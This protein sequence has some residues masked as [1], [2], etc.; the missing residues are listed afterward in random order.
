MHVVNVKDILFLG[1]KREI[2][3]EQHC[4]HRRSARAGYSVQNNT[5]RNQIVR[6]SRLEELC[7]D[8]CKW[9]LMN[10]KFAQKTCKFAEA[11]NS[12]RRECAK[13]K[14]IF[15]AVRSCEKVPCFS[16]MYFKCTFQRTAT[17]EKVSFKQT[18]VTQ[19]CICSQE[20]QSAIRNQDTLR[21]SHG[22][23][24]SFYFYLHFIRNCLK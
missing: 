16:N 9:L 6:I 23:L 21:T 8:S 17:S 18:D 7:S 12:K 24:K 10:W 14:I 5:L 11:K 1:Y 2:G 19:I 15:C 20:A 4:D 3:R 13:I 22:T